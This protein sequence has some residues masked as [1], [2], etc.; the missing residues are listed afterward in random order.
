MVAEKNKKEG[1]SLRSPFNGS[2][3]GDNNVL[4]RTSKQAAERCQSAMKETASCCK[5]NFRSLTN[6][7]LPEMP[8]SPQTLE[9]TAVTCRRSLASFSAKLSSNGRKYQEKCQQNFA[10]LGD[11]LQQSLPWDEIQQV[12]G[13][14][15]EKNAYGDE[16]V[17]VRDAL[18]KTQRAHVES[19][20]EVEMLM[21]GE[22]IEGKSTLRDP[23]RQVTIVTTAA[24]PW[25]TGTSVNPLLRAAFLSGDDTGRNVTLLVPWLA[26]VD[27]QKVFPRDS[28]FETPKEQEEYIRKWAAKR[29][30]RDS[31]F[32]VAFYPGR[33][34]VDKGSILPVGDP[35]EYIPEHE[36]D[37][38]I[39]E[40]P[41]HLTWY[42][43]G[44]RWTDKFNHVV[45]VMHTN[46]LDYARREENGD[47]KEKIL[48]R[49]NQMITRAHCHHVVKL[50]DAVQPLPRERTMFVHGVSPAFLNVGKERALLADNDPTQCVFK[51]GLYFIGKVVWGKG[52]TELVDLLTKH[53]KRVGHNLHVD[54][55]GSGADLPAVQEE[56]EKRHLDLKFFGARD[57]ADASIQDYKVF[58]NPSLSDV[59]ATTT[60]EAI[61]MGK[62]VVCADHPS[63]RFFANFRNCLMYRSEQEFTECVDKALASEPAP[64]SAEEQRMLTWEA[65]T[66]RLIEVTELT[67]KQRPKGLEAVVDTVCWVVHN[68]VMAFEPARVV[69]G[70]GMNTKDNPPNLTDYVPPE[71]EPRGILD[72]KTQKQAN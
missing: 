31:F 16:V 62:F 63:N 71:S 29:T 58:I 43:H 65:A 25:M 35:T 28:I 64:L 54:I 2:F 24:L 57:H 60:A 52:Y 44:R 70:A 36:A 4:L 19:N 13:S 38:A 55:F 22:K 21:R 9:E 53:E 61:A 48:R 30:G 40:E 14:L 69:A 7:K 12:R 42:H 67:D 47:V 66:E 20:R 34:A 56:A 37:I 15:L 50:S 10:Q 1:S 8:K 32:K 72:R 49:V 39:L 33:Y 27:Q 41:E 59:V 6:F 51:K 3:D 68:T 11:I 26:K 18:A 17:S 5:N 46:Y 23:S 45:G